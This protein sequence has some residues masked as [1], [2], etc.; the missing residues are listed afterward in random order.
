LLHYFLLYMF[1]QKKNTENYTVQK[2]NTEFFFGVKKHLHRGVFILKTPHCGKI[3]KVF[4]L[5]IFR[6]SVF[7]LEIPIDS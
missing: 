2:K 6:D 7:V 5:E 4:F 1:K 3:H